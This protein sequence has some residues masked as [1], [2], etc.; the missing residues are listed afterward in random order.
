MI[1]ESESAPSAPGANASVASPAELF[2]GLW[3]PAKPDGF[4]ATL[5]TPLLTPPAP[6]S[7]AESWVS[8]AGAALKS[9]PSRARE[10]LPE[11]IQSRNRI[12]GQKPR[13]CPKF[14]I[15]E[16]GGQL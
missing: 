1:S 12:L 10:S 14:Q 7:C 9:R 15:L 2:A 5:L 11:D 8:A 6:E 13:F 3:T 16:L 4:R